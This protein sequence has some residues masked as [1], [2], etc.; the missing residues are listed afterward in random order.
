MDSEIER[1]YSRK[2]DKFIKKWVEMKQEIKRKR[3]RNRETE[4]KANNNH[5]VQVVSNRSG[6]R[7][8]QQGPWDSGAQSSSA[9]RSSSRPT[10]AFRHPNSAVRLSQPNYGA[11]RQSTSR[12]RINRAHQRPEKSKKNR[13]P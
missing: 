4:R 6:V 2:R 12:E 9:I 1:N 13:P 5:V 8:Q 10:V 3:R 7:Q 11:N